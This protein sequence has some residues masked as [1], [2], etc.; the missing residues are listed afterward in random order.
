[1]ADLMQLSFGC[2]ND[3]DTD[4]LKEGGVILLSP[5]WYEQERA[6][7][8]ARSEKGIPWYPM[9]RRSKRTKKQP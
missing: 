6:K 4:D 5:T 7:Q 1:M 8:R 2:D 3:M 9:K